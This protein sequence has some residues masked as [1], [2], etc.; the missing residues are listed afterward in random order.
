[1]FQTRGIFLQKARTANPTRQ[2]TEAF[3]FGF[4]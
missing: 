4:D 1:L 2:K 3:G